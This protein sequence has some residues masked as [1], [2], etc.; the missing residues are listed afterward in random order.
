MKKVFLILAL[1]LGSAFPVHAKTT[2][3]TVSGNWAGAIWDN[4]APA[5]ADIINIPAGIIVDVYTNSVLKGAGIT[6]LNI[7]GT[8]RMFDLAALRLDAGDG[9]AVNVLSGGTISNGNVLGG[10]VTFGNP[11]LYLPVISVSV[12]GVISSLEGY[13][14]AS[15]LA[16][17]ISMTSGVL[18]IELISFDA[19]V[20]ANQ[21][22]FKWVTASEFNN[23]HFTIERF[24][25]SDKF[26]EVTT[27]PGNGTTNQTTIYE[28]SDFSPVTGKNYYRLKQTDF[29]GQFS[30]SDIVMV[31]FTGVID[32][33]SVYPN[34]LASEELTIDVRDL[35]PEDVV[36]VQII[37]SK[38]VEVF[39]AVY[40]TSK[41]GFA[42]GLVNSNLLQ[43]GIYYV[44]AGAHARKL[45]VE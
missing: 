10:L 8:L 13:L 15:P 14:G 28:A 29:D 11:V 42:R 9:D 23:S 16:G 44:K 22:N 12:L 45:V 3:A 35:K 24:D 38:G 32:Q 39:Q 20:T 25:A 27:L 43:P 6:T 21:V 2:T 18:P 1:A 37:D 4:G 17:P 41:V 30:Y 31:E 40:N 5:S 19:T 33:L 36:R 34:P 26:F 7:A